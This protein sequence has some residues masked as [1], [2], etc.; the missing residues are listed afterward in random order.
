[1]PPDPLFGLSWAHD[2]TGQTGGTP[3]VDM[4]APEAWD[5]TTGAG[6][7][8]MVMD[9]GVEFTHPDLN[10]GWAQDFTGSGGGGAPVHMNDN[11]GTAVSGCI[12][13]RMGGTPAIGNVGIAPSSS[14]AAAKIAYFSD[15]WGSWQVQQSYLVNALWAAQQI[16]V[17]VTNL[18]WSLGSTMSGLDAKYQETYATMVHFASS[19]NDS[20]GTISY[21]ARAPY[22]NAV[23][24]IDHNG[25]RAEFGGGCMNALG[26]S[27]W[28]NEI[29]FTAP[30]EDVITCDRTGAA[31]YVATGDYICIDGTSFSSPYAAGVAA[32]VRSVNPGLTPAQVEMALVLSARDF[33]PAGWDTAYGHGAVDA[34]AA[35]LRGQNFPSTTYCTAGTSTNGCL[36]TISSTGLPSATSTSGFVLTTSNV[37][38][39][40]ACLL[41]YG[42][43][44]RHAAPWGASSSFLCVKSPVQRTPAGNSG[45]FN[46]TCTGAHS[47]DWLAYMSA[48]PT[49]I[50]QPLTP[51]SKVYAQLWY[52]D[53]SAPGTTNLSN[54][55]EFPLLP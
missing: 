22:V 1:M 10:V 50:G 28:G 37:E 52:R 47:I 40:R 27:N 49:A 9:D 45:G 12:A 55:I 3:G 20:V 34:Y 33:A 6:V 15:F 25:V 48:H 54:A 17:G 39:Q 2:N 26:G 4:N 32:L 7:I 31:G 38:G 29:D 14:V 11:H 42:I 21:P 41:F 30:G 44:G 51:G 53:P 36:A 8:V 16:N 13:G 35:V 24:A 5:I 43:S 19:G 18:S 46:A 23:G